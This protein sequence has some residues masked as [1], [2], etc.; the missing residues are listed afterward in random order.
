MP[1]RRTRPDE[2]AATEALTRDAFWNVYQPGCVEHLILHNFRNDP[3]WIPELDCVFE[4]DGELI[5]HIMYCHAHLD[6]EQAGDVPAIM[7]GPVSVRPDHQRQSYGSAIILATMASAAV[8]GHGAVLIT[9]SPAYYSKLG[10]KSCSSR[11]IFYRDADRSDPAEFFMYREL[12]PG[13]LPDGISLFSEPACYTTDPAQLEQFD[14]LFPPRKK[15]R[16][17]GQLR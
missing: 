2:Y 7:F 16:R 5:A 6:S 17:P 10:F 4:V 15:Q 3:A 9:G 8:L 13:Y 11:G 1:I 14:A 12:K